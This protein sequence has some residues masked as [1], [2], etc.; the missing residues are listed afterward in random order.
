MPPHS[1]GGPTSSSSRGRARL[2][3]IEKVGSRSAGQVWFTRVY[4]RRGGGGDHYFTGLACGAPATI[5]NGAIEA[6]DT[7]RC[8]MAIVD[9]TNAGGEFDE[10]NSQSRALACTSRLRLAALEGP[11]RRPLE[12]A[13]VDVEA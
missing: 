13:A 1:C 12:H 3:P 2:A 11:G 5:C 6:G 4:D 10:R 9:S 8:L 7:S